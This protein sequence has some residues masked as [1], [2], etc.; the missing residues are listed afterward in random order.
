MTVW[1][2]RK[3]KSVIVRDQDCEDRE[4]ARERKR[5]RKSR[6]RETTRGKV[7]KP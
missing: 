3:S 4:R 6:V 2:E 1:G 7:R 5:E